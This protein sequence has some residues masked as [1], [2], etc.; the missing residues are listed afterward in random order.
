V[1][2]W[3]RVQS[4]RRNQSRA[5]LLLSLIVG[6]GIITVI[7]YVSSPRTFERISDT[8]SNAFVGKKAAPVEIAPEKKEPEPASPKKVTARRR[9]TTA[10]E[11]AVTAQPPIAGDK[12]PRLLIDFAHAAVKTEA[13]PVYS[14]NSMTSSVVEVLKKGEQVETNLEVIDSEGRWILVRKQQQNQSGFVRSE[15]LER[16]PTAGKA[17]ESS[18]AGE[19]SHNALEKDTSQ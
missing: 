6:C 2:P 11:E 12:T 10:S 16:R 3:E 8:L 7:V 19:G 5:G 18:P 14:Y 15:N 17:T 1:N 9:S 13:A 4:R